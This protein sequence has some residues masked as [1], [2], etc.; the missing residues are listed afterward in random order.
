MWWFVIRGS[1]SDLT[2]LEKEWE[3][4][5]IQT[6]WVLEP[7]FMPKQKP[8]PTVR[9]GA[10][11]SE[12]TGPSMESS[13]SNPTNAVAAPTDPIIENTDSPVSNPPVTTPTN[14][15][16]HHESAGNSFLESQIIVT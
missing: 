14:N 11:S 12:E 16:S 15:N 8:A 9:S 10:A 6:S 2:I 4:V 13:I 7:C 1:E 3:K 5:S